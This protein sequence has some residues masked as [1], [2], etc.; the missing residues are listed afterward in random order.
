MSRVA[1]R[2]R[3]RQVMQAALQLRRPEVAC[4]PEVVKEAMLQVMADQPAPLGLVL[5]EAHSVRAGRLF[6]GP[7]R[8]A[9]LATHKFE[10][11]RESA[12]LLF[13]FPPVG[14]LEGEIPHVLGFGVFP[15]SRGKLTPTFF[16]ARQTLLEGGR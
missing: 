7:S 12:A 2:E 11:E 13:F 10:R 5:G 15:A 9:G 8:G 16:S 14:R 6:F 3:V 1:F 4:G